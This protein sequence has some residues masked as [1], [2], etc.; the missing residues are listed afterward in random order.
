M[1]NKHWYQLGKAQ[2]L[3]AL[4]VNKESGL[5]KTEIVT[6]TSEYGTNQISQKADTSAW[7]ILLSQFKNPLLIILSLGMFLSIYIGH[8]VDAIAIFIIILINLLISFTQEYNAQKS[9]DSLKKMSAPEADV[10]RGGEW[11]TIPAQ[12]LVPGDIVS[13][14]AGSIVPADLR[15]LSAEQL[16]IDEAAL[17]GESEPVHKQHRRISEEEVPVADQNNMAFMSTSVTEG[18]AL[19]LVV[20]TGMQTEVGHIANLMQSSEDPLTPL[21]ARIHKLSKILIAAALIIVVIV[22]SIGLYNGMATDTLIT[23]GISLAVAAIPE[24]LMTVLT[25]VLTLGAKQMM[26][27]NA[28]VRALASVET[29]G[30]TSVICSDKTG[31]L[32]Q[33]KMQVTQLWAADEF[34][35]VTGVGYEPKGD[36]LTQDQQ[37]YHQ[38]SEAL[39]KRMMTISTLCNDA[40][41]YQHDSRYQVRGLPTEGALLAAAQKMDINKSTLLDT[42]QI[43]E[44]FPFNAKRKMMSVLV[45]KNNGQHLLYTKGA[46]DVL[47]RQSEAVHLGDDRLG[48]MLSHS[49]R[50]EAAVEKFA[51]QALRTLAVGYRR[52]SMDQVTQLQTTM[53]DDD[54]DLGIWE[55]DLTLVG[56]HGIID[57]P[58]PEA[59][60]AIQVCHDAGVRVIMITGDHASTAKAIAKQMDIIDR[61]DA[62]VIEGKTLNR[63]NDKAL[64]KAVKNCHV[65]ARVTP[66]HKLR[67]VQALQANGA[68]VAMTGDGVNDA[69]ALRKAEMGVAM[70]ITGTGVS[71]ESSDLILL[72]DNFATIV[73]AIESG[74]RIYDNIR[75]FIRQDLTTNVGEVS[76]L[77]FAFILMTGEPLL[78]LAPLMIL[79]VNLVSDGLPSLALGVDDAEQN[80]MHRKPRNKHESFF[81][82][83][84]GHKILIRGLVLGAITYTMFQYALDQGMPV[85]YAQTLAFMTLIYGQLVLIFDSRT[86]SS[87]YRR[88]P[89]SN[90]ILLLAV[91]ASGTLSTL[92][93]YTPFGNL[94]LGTM[95]LSLEHLALAFFIG[96]LPTFIL[97][98]LKEILKI[99]WL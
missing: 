76:A 6:R 9:I 92:M 48:D 89:F 63:L 67:I 13:L 1:A 7:L 31:T 77:L 66:E 57:P 83:K 23:T 35:H 40:E 95:P 36:I 90:K 85:A 82:N 21:Q 75:K 22:L 11:Q 58:K 54:F 39:L 12:S 68:V 14:K 27:K 8:W 25:I 81:A 97:S 80:V 44:V 43:I 71:K 61:E 41:L 88:N 84:M 87:L 30:S 4:K 34:F 98:G 60:E 45:K 74:R 28:L 3:N 37:M 24:G 29:L 93:V 51:H 46:P 49:R 70:G 64:Q 2:A 65:F 19:G 38:R 16:R 62:K 72:D 69:P 53:N 42:Y 18:N 99:K 73:T 15:L 5:D 17:T 20:G 33:N 50:V 52:L 86:F 96:A 94:A 79:W 32:T 91:A 47:I 55:Q 56:V 10:L 78:T 26:R 59:T